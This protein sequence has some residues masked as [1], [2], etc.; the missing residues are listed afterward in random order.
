MNKPELLRAIQLFEGLAESDLHVLADAL[1]E[2]SARAGEMIFHQGDAAT[3][4]FIIAEGHV[5]IHLPGE[6][7]RRISLKDITRGEYFGELSLFD[8]MPR[9]ASAVATTDV[10]LL[11]LSAA[12]LS[13]YLETRPGAA[14]AI[15]RVMTQRLRATNTL[16]SERAAKNVVEEMDKALTWRDRLADRVAELNG[17]WTFIVALLALTF[18]WAALNLDLSK[19]F[20]AYPFVFYNLLLAVL[21]ALQ[22][23]L[24]VMSQNRQ[25]MKDRAQSETDFQVNLK[26]ETNIEVILRELGEFRAEVMNRLE[27][28]EAPGEAAPR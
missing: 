20:D 25:T 15:L 3:T 14:M 8:D 5:N 19:P 6:H 7:S 26:N 2:R 18:L 28:L 13:S 21:V 1:G 9:S 12:T 22:G 11:E 24:I 16:L 17:S 27:K 10:V 23:P 4:M